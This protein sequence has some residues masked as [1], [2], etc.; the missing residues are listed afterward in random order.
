MT[1]AVATGPNATSS[2]AAGSATPRATVTLGGTQTGAVALA[3]AAD[4]YP[5]AAKSAG[6]ALGGFTATGSYTAAAGSG[7]SLTVTRLHI[8]TAADDLYCSGSGSTDPRNAPVATTAVLTDATVSIASVAGQRPGV[9]GYARPGETATLGGSGWPSSLGTGSLAAEVCGI[10]GAGPCQA[11]A[12]TLTT[13][14]AGGL[15]GTATIPAGATTGSRTLRVTAGAYSA[16]ASLVVLGPRTITL[17][18]AGAA[19]GTPIAVTG[20]NFDPLAA[21]EVRGSTSLLGSPGSDTAD[22][23]VAATARRPARSARRTPT[24][25]PRPSPWSPTR[26]HPAAPRRPTGPPPGSA[27]RAAGP[28]WATPAP[29]ACAPSPPRPTPTPRRSSSATEVPSA[30]TVLSAPL[31]RVRV[32]DRRGGAYGWTLSAA[33]TD[34]RPPAGRPSPRR[35]SR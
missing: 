28:P 2:T 12:H 35:C 24:P 11:A 9:T 34:L 1:L 27:P 26:P 5:A 15:Q 23:P 20:A 22:A 33:A 16:V 7:T 25:T 19:A 3:G 17:S 14:L 32:V 31:N 30:V 21:V 8:D 6:Q 4:S 18:P 10:G 13:T 29:W